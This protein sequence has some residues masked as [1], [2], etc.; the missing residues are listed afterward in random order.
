MLRPVAEG[1]LIHGSEFCQSNAVVV[2]GRAG[3]LLIDPGATGDEI[4]CLANDL[5]ELGQPVVAGFSTQHLRARR[6][7]NQNDSSR[8][9][10]RRSDAPDVAPAARACASCG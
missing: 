2:Q 3:V 4:A 7:R 5:R 10:S 8:A 1:V 6:T 9:L